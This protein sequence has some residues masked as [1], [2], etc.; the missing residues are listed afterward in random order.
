[1]VDF[2]EQSD[3]LNVVQL[4]RA[5]RKG[6][7]TGIEFIEAIQQSYRYH[8]EIE[9]ITNPER[10]TIH[11]SYNPET[12]I[13]L[14]GHLKRAGWKSDG[15]RVENLQSAE[16]PERTRQRRNATYKLQPKNNQQRVGPLTR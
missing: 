12:P 5:Y 7:L 10:Y 6:N 15:V 8:E 9:L 3:T 13:N 2:V 1:M 11:V 16:E 14:H 4:T